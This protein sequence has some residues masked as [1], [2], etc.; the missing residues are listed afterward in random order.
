MKDCLFLGDNYDVG[1]DVIKNY[2]G[3]GIMK[4]FLLH[5][6][7]ENSVSQYEMVLKL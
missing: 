1:T 2:R 3:H 4:K 7:F 6:G 5:L